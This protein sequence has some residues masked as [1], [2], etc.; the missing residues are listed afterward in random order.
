MRSVDGPHAALLV[1]CLG[2]E[3]VL[4]PGVR[5]DTGRPPI[6]PLRVL[7]LLGGHTLGESVGGPLPACAAVGLQSVFPDGDPPCPWKSKVVL[8]L[9]ILIKPRFLAGTVR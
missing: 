2:Q 5:S 4:G 1:S 7:S 8:A 6:V 3:G 9:L